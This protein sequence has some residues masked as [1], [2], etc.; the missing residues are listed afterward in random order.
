MQLSILD[1]CFL[2]PLQDRDNLQLLH[3]LI[4]LTSPGK[5]KSPIPTKLTLV[6]SIELM[7]LLNNSQFTTADNLSNFRNP[8]LDRYRFS[9]LLPAISTVILL[10]SSL[11]PCLAAETDQ[12]STPDSDPIVPTKLKDVR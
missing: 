9:L 11:S 8:W 7:L 12:I 4:G 3:Q 6:F 5:R 1:F 10:F 2:K